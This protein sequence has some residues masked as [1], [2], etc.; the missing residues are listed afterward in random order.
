MRCGE[1]ADDR[2]GTRVETN[3]LV[4]GVRTEI[5]SLVVVQTLGVLVD[6]V[7][8]YFIEECPIVG[9]DKHGAGVRLEIC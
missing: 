2:V 6:D 5:S 9:D 1:E 4:I 3:E 8:R 7:C